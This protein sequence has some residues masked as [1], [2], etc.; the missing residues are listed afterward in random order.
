MLF[1]V[2][3]LLN[4]EPVEAKGAWLWD[5]NG[6][7]YL[8][9]YGGHAVISIG[10]SHPL[11]V[12]RMTKQ[13]Q[14]I[15]FY[16]NAVVNPL[17][18]ELALRLE[19]ISGCEDYSLFLCNSGA[20]AN[21]NALKLASFVTGREK[22]LAFKGAFHGRTSAAVAVTD[23]PDIQAPLN[24]N[25]KVFFAPLNDFRAV[26]KELLTEEYAA[27]I[28]EGI[29]GVGGIRV[30]EHRF[31][32]RLRELCNETGTALVADEVQSGCGRTGKFFAH[33]HTGVRADMITMAKGMG[34]G[35]PV[36]GVMIMKGIAAT[37][38]M[39]GTTFGGGHLAC[40]AALAVVEVIDQEKL[41][42]NA[43]VLGNYLAGELEKI[44]GVAEVRGKGLMIG[45]ELEMPQAEFRK[46]LTERY[47]VLTGY[48][49]KSTLRL[50]PPLTITRE[51]ADE[52]LDA[53]R[54]T[55]NEI[56]G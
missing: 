13:L 47:H 24:K 2:Y 12:A 7:K 23:N 15:G 55:M 6:A 17:Q 38:G 45:V 27:V 51:E 28:L 20:E 41:M 8:D 39:L 50:L 18:S 9:F 40:A 30:L 19:R 29:Q 49:G 54:K 21:E 1:E 53:F 3:D 22:V 10:H 48:S 5:R 14:K 35:F 36:A 26:E 33:Q 42:H 11:Y 52:F 46:R 43:A 4:I 32:L 31:M 16:S 37:K 34:N 56:N 25:H 44:K